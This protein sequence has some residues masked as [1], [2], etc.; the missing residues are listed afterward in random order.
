MNRDI[1]SLMEDAAKRGFTSHFEFQTE[2]LLCRETGTSYVT[3]R[4][5]LIEMLQPDPG[6][7]PGGEAT[8]YLLEAE[9]GEKGMLLIGNPAS[10]SAQERATLAR[11]CNEGH[12]S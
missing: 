12:T 1:P 7:D 2:A 8:L 10:L 5:K 6:S 3:E 9:D 11:I 4:L